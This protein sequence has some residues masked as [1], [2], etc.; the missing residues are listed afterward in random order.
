[1]NTIALL[2]AAGQSRRFGRPKLLEPCHGKPLLHHALSP[3]LSRYGNR[4]WVVLGENPAALLPHLAGAAWL[5]C[6]QSQLGLGH[7]IAAAL[8]QLA[9]Q[10]WDGVLIALAD[11]PAVPLSHFDRLTQR[12]QAT[13]E[14]V[15]S[16]YAG[17]KGAPALFPRHCLA[18]LQA[19]EGDRGAQA[20]LRS[21][22]R[23]Q[24]IELGQAAIDIDEPADLQRFLAQ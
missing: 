6:P 15:A 21:V 22:P 24:V 23:S 5:H 4:L 18:Q 13:G 1:M 16:G 17:I 20:L 8:R 2:M 7:S 11:Q 3:L 12:F 9:D 14:I 10:P 19:L